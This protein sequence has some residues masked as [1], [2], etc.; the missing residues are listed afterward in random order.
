M[1]IGFIKDGVCINVAVFENLLTAQAMLKIGALGEVDEVAIVP[2]HLGIGD[3]CYEGKWKMN[4]D[5][6]CEN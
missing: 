5:K 1:T 6:L 3:F 4:S 2:K